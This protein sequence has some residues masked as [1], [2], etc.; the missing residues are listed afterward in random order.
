MQA[1]I[2]EGGVLVGRPQHKRRRHGTVSA[3]T[4]EPASSWPGGCSKSKAKAATSFVAVGRVVG[5]SLCTRHLI[6]PYF[7]PPHYPIQTCF[8]PVPFMSIP[9]KRIQPQNSNLK[10]ARSTT[11]KTT[12]IDTV[13]WK[14]YVSPRQSSYVFQENLLASQDAG[15]FHQPVLERRRCPF[16]AGRG[17]VRGSG[18][19]RSCCKRGGSGAVASLLGCTVLT[20]KERQHG[21]GQP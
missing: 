20:N 16:S 12:S 8:M 2:H 1:A 5:W 3:A 6:Y 21:G 17:F 9:V 13:K 14:H 7:D 10:S 18:S 15:L 11:P 4:T 19:C